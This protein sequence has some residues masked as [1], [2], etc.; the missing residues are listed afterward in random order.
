MN[1]SQNSY[2]DMKKLLDKLD[3]SD[4]MVATKLRER[5]GAKVSE[6]AI[7]KWRKRNS[8]PCQHVF[9]VLL[10]LQ[11]GQKSKTLDFRKFLL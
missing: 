7:Y 3:K 8:I 10:A 1:K 11:D 9:N 5:T 6:A 2:Y 4:N